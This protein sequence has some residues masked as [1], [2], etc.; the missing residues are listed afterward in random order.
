M[1]S[2]LVKFFLSVIVQKTT[3]KANNFCKYSYK[4]TLTIYLLLLYSMLFFSLHAVLE[5]GWWWNDANYVVHHVTELTV[6]SI[7]LAACSNTQERLLSQ[8]ILFIALSLKRNAMQGSSGDIDTATT[9]HSAC[10]FNRVTDLWTTTLE[11]LGLFFPQWSLPAD[12]THKWLLELQ[13][14]SGMR[15]WAHCH[16]I[17]QGQHVEGTM[18]AGTTQL[19]ESVRRSLLPGI[20][21]EPPVQ[22]A[23]TD[24]LWEIMKM[25][26]LPLQASFTRS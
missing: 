20:W 25:S 1:I 11:V 7:I 18:H 17:M 13:T 24:Q 23:S 26:H 21:V 15:C 12:C 4:E 3:C 5:L 6:S 2:T 16:T 14:T 19:S 9:G 10:L 8:S 22:A